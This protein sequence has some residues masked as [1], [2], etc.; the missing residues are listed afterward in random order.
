MTQPS[1]HGAEPSLVAQR[2]PPGGA[3]IELHSHSVELSLDSGASAA[4]LIARA[5]SSGLD[6]ICLTEH[7]ALWEPIDLRS[8]RSAVSSRSSRGSNLAQTPDTS[9]RSASIATGPSF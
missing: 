3:L 2:R 1:P 6:A 8:L 7:N 5:K 4:S 9:L